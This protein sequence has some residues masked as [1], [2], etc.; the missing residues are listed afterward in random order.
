MEIRQGEIYWV[1]LGTPSGSEPGY[2]RPCVIV[3]NN[4]FNQSRI[5]TL[6]VCILTTNLR[7][8]KAPGNVLLEVNEGGLPKQSVVNVSQL[9]TIDRKR[10]G[11]QIGVLSDERIAEMVR[12]ICLVLEPRG[13]D[14]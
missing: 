13:A 14:G 3:Q 9:L 4:A 6:V 11:K 8:A 2:R 7:L 5:A 1:E 10:L 12:G